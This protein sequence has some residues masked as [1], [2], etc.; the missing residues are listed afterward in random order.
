M[1]LST[2]LYFPITGQFELY[3]CYRGEFLYH[4]EVVYNGIISWYSRACYVMDGRATQI[5]SIDLWAPILCNSQD[6]ITNIVDNNSIRIEIRAD[7][8]LGISRF[9]LRGRG[10]IAMLVNNTLTFSY[11]VNLIIVFFKS[12]I[13]KFS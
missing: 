10:V 1:S 5:Q 13:H 12:N 6:A 7:S 4:S 2:M 11:F 9:P 3:I 8:T